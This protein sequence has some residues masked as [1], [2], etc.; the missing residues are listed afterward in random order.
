[1]DKIRRQFQGAITAPFIVRVR[2]S[3]ALLLIVQLNPASAFPALATLEAYDPGSNT[4]ATKAAMPT[5]RAD[6]AVVAFNGLL[7][8]IGGRGADGSPLATVEAYNPAT[9]TWAT[10]PSIRDC[11]SGRPL[12]R[13]GSPDAAL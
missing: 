7:Y 13:S 3:A 10:E 6:L 4:W 1:M 12:H 8:A 2:L 5:A 9:D 11:G